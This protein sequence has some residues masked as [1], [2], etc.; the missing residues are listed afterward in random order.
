MKEMEKMVRSIQ[1]NGLLW[2]AAVLYQ[3]NYDIRKLQIM[4]IIEDEKASINLLSE[5]IKAFV[6]FELITL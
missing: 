2:G 1:I 5:Q 3:L 4:C 6:V